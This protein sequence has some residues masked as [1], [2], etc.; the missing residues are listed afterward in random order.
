MKK[1]YKV[2]DPLFYDFCRIPIRESQFLYIG[3][4]FE[5]IRLNHPK[6]STRGEEN[7]HQEGK[8]MAVSAKT[9]DVKGR[10][11]RWTSKEQTEKKDKFPVGKFFAW[12]SRD[13]SLAGMTI[14]LGYLS[15]YSSVGLGLSPAIVG[16]LL[17]VSKIFDGVTDFIFGYVIDKTGKARPFELTLLGSW[18]C[19]VLMFSC[20]PAL[21]TTVKCI[22][23]F[24]TYVLVISVFNTILGAD[25]NPYMIR[26]FKSQ[27]IIVKVASYGG[28][29]ST[30]GAMAVSITFPILMQ[31]IPF[32]GGSWSTLVLIYAIPLALLGMLRY[33][34]VKEDTSISAKAAADVS[35]KGIL[36][37]LVN[38]KYIWWFALMVGFNN[39]A[40]SLGAGS[41]YFTYIVGSIGMQSVVS[42]IS[43]VMLPM[44]FIFPKLMKKYSVTGLIT[45]GMVL[46]IVGYIINFFAGANMIMLVIA[47]SLTAVAALPLS[48]LQIII[49][50]N[51]ATYNEWKGMPRLESS[52]GVMGGFVSKVFG[53]IGAGLGGIW[54]GAAGFISTT[55]T[56]QV[57]TQPASAINMIRL[58]YSLIP[59]ALMA[60]S[61]VCCI[62][63]SRLDK[64][65]P[66][67]QADLA[68]RKAAM[69]DPAA[70]EE[71]T[72]VAEE[73]V[74][75]NVVTK[76]L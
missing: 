22:W 25:A 12:K 64:S 26:A 66:K 29:V 54:L 8:K 33:F 42:A 69:P 62:F 18:L 68:E 35:V 1:V 27:K 63:L 61:L 2:P 20:P 41:F 31:K 15:L 46:S 24:V 67:I 11:S 57:I 37:M 4:S 74:A 21:S 45:V 14:I 44:L 36:K 53:G 40:G 72:A 51:L 23:L 38:N 73:N 47:T 59:A 5:L 50:M 13:V 43:I 52:T 48:Y 9:V 60:A 56:A 49:I 17:M 3:F 65:M 55:D 39:F 71:E 30:L 76:E 6:S 34:F 70:L 28:V 7:N 10:K 58:E 75:E 16:T 19:T 32:S